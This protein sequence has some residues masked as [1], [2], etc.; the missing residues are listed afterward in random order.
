MK[1]SEFLQSKEYND[2]MGKIRSYSKGFIF[3]IP[4]YQMNKAQKNGMNI[5]LRNAIKEGLIESVS[6]G[7]SLEGDITEE[8]Y[9]KL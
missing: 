1:K 8:T 9:K 5:V 7:L 2:M 6:F 3:T 4:F